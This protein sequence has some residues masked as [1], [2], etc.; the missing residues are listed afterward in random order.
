MLWR[1]AEVTA[2]AGERLQ[3]WPRKLSSWEDPLSAP[4]QLEGHLGPGSPRE[5]PR[6]VCRGSPDRSRVITRSQRQMRLA[7]L[8]HPHE[9]DRTLRS[10]AP[11]PQTG[12]LPCGGP[13]SPAARRGTA[14]PGPSS[15]VRSPR[16]PGGASPCPPAAAP[17]CWS[18][19]KTGTKSG[20]PAHAQPGAHLA[21]PDLAPTCVC[22]LCP[23]T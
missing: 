20:S 4:A 17:A 23:G 12:R 16:A 21:D 19:S 11:S 10:H 15:A 1:G 14:S 5:A 22:T 18:L 7:S 13:P 8:R 9:R 2:N 6:L 3:P